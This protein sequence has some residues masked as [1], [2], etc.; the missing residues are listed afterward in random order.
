VAS[1][2]PPPAADRSKERKPEKASAVARPLIAPCQSDVELIQAPSTQL[3]VCTMVSVMVRVEKFDASKVPVHVPDR[4][5]NGP[6]GVVDD[7]AG[8]DEP[9]ALLTQRS[10]EQRSNVRLTDTD[11][12]VLTSWPRITP[13][14]FNAVCT[15]K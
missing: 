2:S 14:P 4:F 11:Y 3:P 15:L 10:I 8:D 12:C 9:H 5:A 6:V 1:H 7:G 13:P